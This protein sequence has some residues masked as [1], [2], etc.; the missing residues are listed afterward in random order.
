MLLTVGNVL[1][2]RTSAGALRSAL[3]PS[4][5]SG[6]TV[7]DHSAI[8]EIAAIT[9]PATFSHRAPPTFLHRTHAVTTAV[10]AAIALV[11]RI[12]IHAA[13]MMTNA[14]AIPAT[15]PV[16]RVPCGRPSQVESTTPSAIAA[17]RS[18]SSND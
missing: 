13:V 3:I 18:E 4:G 7:D 10:Q 12:R 5:G 2:A 6:T 8:T 9:T 11:S 16:R 1:R 17:V 15:M 14:P